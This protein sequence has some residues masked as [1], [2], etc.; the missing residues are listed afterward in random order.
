[1]GVTSSMRPTRNPALAKARI[2]AWA[3]APG[4]LAPEPPGART[5]M[6]IAV[7]P[8]SLAIV[9][10]WDAALMVAYADDS[11]RSDFTCIPPED[12]AMVSAPEMSVK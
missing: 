5:L 10:A 4:V 7:I 8:L 11:S 9:A 3:P 1:M 12:R 6:C 2:A